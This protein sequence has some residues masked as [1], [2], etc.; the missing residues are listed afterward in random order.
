MVLTMSFNILHSKSWFCFPALENSF[1]LQFSS[2]FQD[3]FA[4][5]R[6]M[7]QHLQLNVL[8]SKLKPSINDFTIIHFQSMTLSKP[9]CWHRQNGFNLYNQHLTFIRQPSKS[10][11]THCFLSSSDSGS[12][13]AKAQ[14]STTI[15]MGSSYHSPNSSMYF[16]IWACTPASS[17]SISA[18]FRFTSSISTS[19][20]SSKVST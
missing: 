11:I 17:V 5:V 12:R 3:H 1:L 18:M 16:F 2:H 8:H 19:S 20:S 14:A 4:D 15:C 7:V 6:K 13:R 9:F 10:E